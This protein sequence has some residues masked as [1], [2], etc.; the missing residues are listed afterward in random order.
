MTVRVRFAPSPTG[1]LHL[2]N[3]RT[4][5][6]NFLFSKKNDGTFIL[7][8][9]D[10]DPDRFVPESESEILSSLR[11]L[12]ITPDEG[13]S[14][15]GG[16]GPYRQSE[17][18]HLYRERAELLLR[19]GKA[20]RCYCTDEELSL[21]RRT[22]ASRGLPPRYPGTCRDLTQNEIESRGEAPFAIRFKVPDASITVSD[23]IRGQITFPTDAFGDFV[24]IRADGSA[25]YN[26]SSVVDDSLM[27]ITHVIRGEDH[28]PNTPRQIL[29]YEALGEKVP[30]FA[31]HPLL[32]LSSGDKRSKR[33]DGYS[34]SQLIE[35][36]Y[37]PD[38]VFTYLASLGNPP[39]H[40]LGKEMAL[41][42]DEIK[43]N[44]DIEKLGRAPVA[45]QPEELVR[46]SR[47]FIQNMNDER[48][49]EHLSPFLREAGVKIDDW[50]PS[51]LTRFASSVKENIS[52][53][54]EATNFAPLFFTELPPLSDDAR[55]LLSGEDARNVLSTLL[56]E[57]QEI[58]VL[59]SD[60]YGDVLKRAIERSGV[61]GR[62]FFMPLRA[63]LTGMIAGP[64][65][66]PIAVTIGL[67]KTKARINRA[68][69]MIDPSG[70]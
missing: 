23:L 31:H 44:F 4:A 25:V 40:G 64:E 33:E 2:G 26:F 15:G 51:Y 45:V 1:P 11:W 69:E 13:P 21:A 39:I 54:S 36:G 7:R 66:E 28:L 68:L 24:I 6:I 3:A 61:T 53:F 14:I 52:L 62:S 8:I 50:D 59:D 60:C 70:R 19:Q 12:G 41:S 5:V 35:K 48:L 17:R 30:H 49:T 56:T 67:E 38:A 10:T 55:G 34:L 42:I 37:C 57:L 18:G 9:E 27:E 16:Y 32:M 43:N 29:L 58:D 65:L 22:A 46:I 20:F 63:A 47:R